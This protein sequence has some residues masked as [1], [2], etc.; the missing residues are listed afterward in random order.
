VLP[1]GGDGK[2][3]PKGDLSR[4]SK[5]GLIRLVGAAEQ[6]NLFVGH[7]LEYP[8]LAGR[9]HHEATAVLLNIPFSIGIIRC[10]DELYDSALTVIQYMVT[11]AHFFSGQIGRR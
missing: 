7:G 2:S 9:E 3:G 11:G 6:L 4:C 8:A 1:A 5:E 10:G